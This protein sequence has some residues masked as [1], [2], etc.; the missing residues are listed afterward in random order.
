MST[1][2]EESLGTVM[3]AR[4]AAVRA[5][6]WA[7]RLEYPIFRS[8]K[9]KQ[10]RSSNTNSSTYISVPGTLYHTNHA[11]TY[12]VFYTSRNV[13]DVCLSVRLF[14]FI[15]VVHPLAEDGQHFHVQISI[16]AVCQ[17]DMCAVCQS[18]PVATAAQA[19]FREMSTSTVN[20]LPAGI[21]PKPPTATE[22]SSFSH[23]CLRASPAGRRVVILICPSMYLSCVLIGY[24]LLTVNTAAILQHL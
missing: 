14:H 12:Q 3:A 9:N 4:C 18:D 19:S 2:I 6:D 11:N 10:Q 8:T 23:Y 7:E 17:S 1:Y 24:I 13:R 22:T 20:L 21:R 5:A 16:W 15:S